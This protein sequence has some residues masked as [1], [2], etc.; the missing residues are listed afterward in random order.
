[1]SHAFTRPGARLLGMQMN[2]SLPKPVRQSTRT[3]SS[4]KSERS[5]D[6]ISTAMTL[7]LIYKIPYRA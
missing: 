2:Q 1:M 5:P 7:V 4:E 3:R 6:A